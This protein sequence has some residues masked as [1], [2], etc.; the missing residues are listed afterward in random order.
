MAVWAEP[1]TQLRLPKIYNLRTDPFEFADTTSNTY[2]DWIFDHAFVLVPAQH[3]VQKFMETF[4]EFPPRQKPGSF[5]VQQA[6]EKLQ[7][8]G[9]D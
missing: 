7:K 8:S 1:F 6:Q 2:W 9:G 3:E 5:T 4:A